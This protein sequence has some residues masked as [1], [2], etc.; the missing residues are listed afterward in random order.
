M[1]NFVSN[2]R[3]SFVYSSVYHAPSCTPNISKY[4]PLWIPRFEIAHTSGPIGIKFK[5]ACMIKPMYPGQFKLLGPR[6][7]LGM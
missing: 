7:S 3:S 2:V 5:L 6:G 1:Q 4:G